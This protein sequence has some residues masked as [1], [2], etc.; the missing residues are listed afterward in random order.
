MDGYG[1]LAGL[2]GGYAQGRQLRQNRDIRQAQIK[3]QVVQDAYTR[4]HQAKMEDYAA[5]RLKLAENPIRNLDPAAGT[6]F[7]RTIA[8]INKYYQDWHTRLGKAGTIDNIQAILNEGTDALPG[9]R[10]RIQSNIDRWGKDIGYEGA[11]PDMFLQPMH[12]MRT[13]YDPATGRYSYVDKDEFRR[14]Y[15]PKTIS[16]A[17]MAYVRSQQDAIRKTIS[18]PEQ[19][20]TAMAAVKQGL[21]AKYGEDAANAAIP[22]LP[23]DD[24]PIGQYQTFVPKEGG[25]QPYTPEAG[26]QLPTNIN[27]AIGQSTD[28][29]S[30]RRILDPAKLAAQFGADA[31]DPFASEAAK[32]AYEDA[33]YNAPQSLGTIEPVNINPIKGQ[34]NFA[35]RFRP[36]VINAPENYADRDKEFRRAFMS[37]VMSGPAAGKTEEEVGLGMLVQT[38]Q[39]QNPNFNPFKNAEDARKILSLVSPK[40]ADMFHRVVAG[41]A[42]EGG[43][44]RQEGKT[45][46][47]PLT[48]KYELTPY[49]STNAADAAGKLSDQRVIESKTLL[50]LRAQN[51]ESQ[52]KERNNQE[53]QR[54]WQRWWEQYKFSDISKRGW[55]QIGIS[56]GN[57]DL[58]RLREQFNERITNHRV[59][60]EDVKLVQSLYKHMDNEQKSLQ[61]RLKAVDTAITAQNASI[62][63]NGGALSHLTGNERQQLIDG[64]MPASVRKA[65]IV[66]NTQATAAAALEQLGVFQKERTAI[67]KQLQSTADDVLQAK[68]WEENMRDEIKNNSAN[69]ETEVKLMMKQN[70]WSEQQAQAK[71]ESGYRPKSTTGKP[72]GKPQT[73]PKGTSSGMPEGDPFAE[74]K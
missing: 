5:R 20:R 3:R 30:I 13:K 10:A 59:T 8:D 18:N 15:A 54:R 73:K 16:D 66:G 74:P 51:I 69:R 7:D 17:D 1:L 22:F 25:Y 31:P 45:E 57:L 68:T 62:N 19:Q 39:R 58:N 44:E 6:N 72:G 37:R 61:M 52:I 35:P 24:V 42:N 48:S 56:Q 70:G 34:F 67:E 63:L 40:D 46:T 32:R 14:T 9:F 36:S 71:W 47:L 53:T 21:I 60:N 49:E 2:L 50:P 23:L 11:D 12:G 43:Y 33:R 27:P 28:T 38:F 29:S 64:T 65:K 55:A 26:F 4:A 41:V